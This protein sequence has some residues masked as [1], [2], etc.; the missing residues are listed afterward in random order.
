MHNEVRSSTAP[1]II[2]LAFNPTIVLL[3][4]AN[5]DSIGEQKDNSI[6]TCLSTK[7]I[8]RSQNLVGLHQEPAT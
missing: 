7:I 1:A 5:F 2:F 4:Q 3:K 6:S 8:Y